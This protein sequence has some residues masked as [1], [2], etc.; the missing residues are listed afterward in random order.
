VRTLL[1]QQLLQLGILVLELLQP[2]GLG[3][4]D[5]AVF[6]L[7]IIQRRFRDAVLA[8]KI[9]CLRPGLVLDAAPQ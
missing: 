4:I 8:R 5:A 3:H 1:H 7:P 2:L 6:G 9:R